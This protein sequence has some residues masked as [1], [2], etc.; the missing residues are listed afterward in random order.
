M[1]NPEVFVRSECPRC[2][3][4]CNVLKKSG[5]TL[6]GICCPECGGSGYEIKWIP[7]E[8]LESVEIFDL[9][10]RVES[11]EAQILLFVA[12]RSGA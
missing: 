9:T 8:D 1:K 3:G 5:G 7:L 10:K 11:L 12:P 4:S 2:K 6:E